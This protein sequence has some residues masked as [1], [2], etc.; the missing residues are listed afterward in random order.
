[1]DEADYVITK[2][3]IQHLTPE[4]QDE[5]LDQV[6]TLVGEEMAENLSDEQLDEYEKIINADDE[7]IGAWLAANEPDYEQ[8][9][10]YQA[11]ADG[12]EADPEHNDPKK[13]FANLQWVAKNFPNLQTVLDQVIA[14]YKEGLGDVDQMSATIEE[15]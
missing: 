12:T 7:V 6:F 4:Q 3:G 2:L 13:I 1:M 11:I 14:A 5:I 9:E 15:K 10:V 8:N